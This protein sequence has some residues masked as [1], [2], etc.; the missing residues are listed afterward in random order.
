MDH[1]DNMV[2]STGKMSTN[3]VT[4]FTSQLC[5][6]QLRGADAIR[7]VMSVHCK[8]GVTRP[9]G[10][11]PE[12]WNDEWHEDDGGS[13]LR[14]CRPQNGT[15]LLKAEMD[16]LSFRGGYEAAWDDASN[17]E[18]IPKLVREARELEMD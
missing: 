14:G 8:N 12:R 11:Y 13:D 17:A 1:K 15:T 18:L 5:S 3:Q 4:S 7:K 16:G 10:D 9:T 2:V 6:L